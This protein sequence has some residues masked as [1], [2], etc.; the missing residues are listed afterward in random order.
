[1]NPDARPC[2]GVRIAVP[3]TYQLTP[4]VRRVS[5]PPR[6][7][8]RRPPPARSRRVLLASLLIL[9]ASSTP[10]P[11]ARA[12]EPPA[13]RDERGRGRGRRRR[14]ALRH[15]ARAPGP[16]GGDVAVDVAVA[17]AVDVGARRARGSDVAGRDRAT[18][19]GRTGGPHD[20]KVPPHGVSA[21]R[22]R[23]R[24]RDVGRRSDESPGVLHV[25]RARDRVRVSPA[26]PR[27]RA[28]GER[29]QPRSRHRVLYQ[30][31]A[32]GRRAGAG[33]TSGKVLKERRSPR[34]RGRMGTSV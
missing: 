28:R 24:R 32:W 13:S 8:R 18:G 15:D 22:R 6:L 30:V 23:P 11:S 14:R 20:R 27:G 21:R 2:V 5:L 16:R 4:P 17:V 29:Q 9:D 10:L 33:R 1:M 19:A 25:L 31:T 3:A 7:P 26:R 12:G 34:E